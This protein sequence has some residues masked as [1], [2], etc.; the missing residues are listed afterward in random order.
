M[1]LYLVE[2]KQDCLG[3]GGLHTHHVE[4]LRCGLSGCKCGDGVRQ[5]CVLAGLQCGRLCCGPRGLG[6]CTAQ[7]THSQLVSYLNLNQLPDCR[8]IVSFTLLSMTG[9]G[10]LATSAL[11][12]PT[13]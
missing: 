5:T 11:L 9:Q 7:H 10:P 8:K 12:L 4:G 6:L 3:E 1:A 2:K 13:R